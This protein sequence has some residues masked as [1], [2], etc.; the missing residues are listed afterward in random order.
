MKGSRNDNLEKDSESFNFWK[1]HVPEDSRILNGIKRIIFGKWERR[2]LVVLA[3]KYILII[4][5]DLERSKI[6]GKLLVN[7]DHPEVI[8]IWNLVFMQYN[9]FSNGDLKKLPNNHVDTGMGLERLAMILQEKN[10]IMIRIFFN[11]L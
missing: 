10:L 1:K 7:Q 2:D 4:E 6:D 8:E 5:H 11:Q 3:L 9:R